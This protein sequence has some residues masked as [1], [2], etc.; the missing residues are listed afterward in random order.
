MEIL[1]DPTPDMLAMPRFDD[2]AI[3]M[4]ELLRR[5]AE[6]V[7]NAVMDAEADQLCGGGAN[8][9]NG[10]RE[11]SLATCVGTLTLRIPKLRSGSFFPEDV[12][13]R[14][15]RVD[16]A[17][18]AAVA[19]MYA[20]G[21][22]TRKVQRV[23]EKMG[24]SRLSKDQVSAI[25][26]SLDAD[27]EDLCG[28]PLDGSPVPYV[29]LDATYVKCRREGRVAS[30]AVV[31]AIG[32]DAGGWRRVLGV[33]VVDTESYDS[34]LA[35]L[36]AIRSRGAAGVRLV[37]SDAHPGLVRAL[38]EVFQGAAWQRCAVHLMRDCMREAGSRQLGRRA[39]RIVSSAFR[40][41]D[42][43]TA[44]AM[45]HA[46]CE[47]LEGCRPRAAR[48][49]EEAEPDALAYL[50]FPPSHWKRPRTNSVQERANGEIKRRSRVVQVFPSE[51]SPLRLVGAV[52]CDQA[53]TWSGSRHFSERRMA[54]MHD[55]A[56]RMGAAGE[57][58]WAGLEKAARKT[59]ESSLE[60]ADSVEAA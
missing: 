17:L 28:R 55:A 3:D 39:G 9:R 2:G 54:E 13:E 43:A 49:L 24:V 57:H 37:V 50:D 51:S 41:G 36:R 58:D 45:Y 31:T 21:T 19:E 44:A 38:G 4:Q 5:L 8:S 32:C 56:F 20:T 16:R 42:A 52:M 15:Q 34:W 1:S 35:F 10:Y 59:I 25:A 48:T 46:A 29:W 33:D 14:Y 60:L 30:T 47:M 40:A 23:A 22:S 12:L 7:V 6:Q 11:R 26:S 53:E 27:I 18:V